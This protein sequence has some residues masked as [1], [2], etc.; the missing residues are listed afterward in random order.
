VQ[1]Q[2][3]F[4]GKV[5]LVTGATSGIGRTASLALAR[6]G[7]RVVAVGRR[8]ELGVALVEEIEGTGGV[9]FFVAADVSLG[10]GCARMVQV[11][12]ER[13]GGLHLAFNNAGTGGT[14]KPL[15]EED[16]EGFDRTIAV[17]L[18]SVFLSM[19]HEIPAILASGG[20]AIVNTSS[21]AGLNGAPMLASY[22]ASKHG[23]IGLTKS[24]AIEL[25]T[26]GIRVNALCPGGTKTEMLAGLF[27][28]PEMERRVSAAHPIGRMADTDEVANVALF[29]LSDAASFVTGQGWAVDGGLT[30]L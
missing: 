9:A 15:V 2:G 22:S 30:A 20:G 13:F 4:S 6:E 1:T 5:A 26:H 10:A 11:A 21:V 23:V 7:A 29:L 17:N 16:E 18:R 27:A 25:A 14:H 24:A 3:R 28:N 19:R 12:V 8:Q